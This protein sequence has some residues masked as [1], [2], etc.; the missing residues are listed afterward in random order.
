METASRRAAG[1]GDGFRWREVNEIENRHD[2]YKA[3]DADGQGSD[4][5]AEAKQLDEGPQNARSK[6]FAISSIHESDFSLARTEVNR[7]PIARFF[8]FSVLSV[9]SCLI[10]A[11]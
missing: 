9:F 2:R 10:C 6:R 7:K 5:A 1:D 3:N 4:P 11:A 8:S